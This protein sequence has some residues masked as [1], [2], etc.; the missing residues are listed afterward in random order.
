MANFEIDEDQAALIR[1]LRKLETSDPVHANVYNALFEKLINNDA[2][3]ERLANKMVEK[4][5]L[6]HVLDSVNA[7]Q[8]LAAD[9]GP[10][11]TAITNELKENV[12]V[13]NTKIADT[14]GIANTA[15]AK[16]ELD[17]PIKTIAYGSD[18]NKWAFQQQFPD[19]VILSLGISETEIF[20]DYYDGKTWTRKWTR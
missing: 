11:I 19:G 6:C 20:Y 5:M 2:F 4:S 14:S 13:L 8:V 16:I 12:S 17:G 18:K 7:Q 3:L 1:E 15:N 10:K 9:V